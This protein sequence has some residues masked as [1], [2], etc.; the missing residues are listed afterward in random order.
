MELS[1]IFGPQRP[2]APTDWGY[3]DVALLVGFAALS[4]LFTM[5]LLGAVIGGY[6]LLTGREVN[7]EE[8]SAPLTLALGMQGLW[9]LMIL[10]CVYYIVAVRHG[11]DFRPAVGWIGFQTP[12]LNFFTLGIVMA[13]G[14]GALSQVIPM[15]DGKMPIEE[16]L[17]SHEAVIAMAIFGVF[18]APPIE[19]LVFRG[20]LFP[21]LR[22]AHGILIAVFGTAAVFAAVHAQQ[23]AYH[24]QVLLILFMV[25]SV[26]GWI[27]ARTGSVI[28][29]TLTHATY[30]ATLF[31]ALLFV[32]EETLRQL[33]SACLR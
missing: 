28:A 15:P 1:P 21:V 16:L 33:E 9:W 25:G 7:L 32:D 30:N 22:Q 11:R 29:S 5:L 20:F 3:R 17:S 4:L 26:L 12:A 18:V 8:G 24:W 6:A 23:Y 13:F 31:A 10:A 2:L 19:E 14:V 27:R